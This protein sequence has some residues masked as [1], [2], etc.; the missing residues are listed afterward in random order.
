MRRFFERQ[1]LRSVI[2]LAAPIALL[3]TGLVLQTTMATLFAGRLGPQS[4]AT[5]GLAGSTYFLILIAA[6]GLLLGIDP[7]SSQAFGAGERRECAEVLVHA[8]ILAMLAA[9]P[10]FAVM[11]GTGWFLKAFGVEPALAA[12][13]GAY[14]RI[15]R[16]GVFP[17]LL[18]T[19]CR[20]YL[21]TLSITLP[22]LAGVVAADA[23]A[24]VLDYGLMFGHF[25][26]PALGVNGAAF[27]MLAA[28]CTMLAVVAVAAAR[29]VSSSGWLWT[30]FKTRIF[31]ELVRLGVPAS[32]QMLAEVGAFSLTSLLCGR[33]GSASS[34]AH[35]IVLN[36]ASLSFMV[37]LGVSHAAAVRVGQG[38]GHRRADRAVRSAWDALG[39]GIA[40]MSLTCLA[41]LLLGRAIMGLYTSDN[42]VMDLGVRLLAIAGV[43]QVFDAVQVIMT[44]S[45]RGLG[46]TRAPM[47]VNAVGYYLVG[48]PVGGYLAFGAGWGAFGLWIGVC[49]GLCSVAVGLLAFWVWR[50]RR[51][52]AEDPATAGVWDEIRAPD[53]I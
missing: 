16:W 24:A 21:Q 13:T 38:I 10:V 48:L 34:A 23:V 30:G 44:G 46:E 37:P 15:L 20:Q 29:Q 25:G 39:L 45:L 9:L 11:S 2:I 53:P 40:F 50:S 36:L 18:F 4:I 8:V 12:S 31:R 43:F 6:F 42:G 1:E 14:L 41:Y 17:M 19:A 47:I 52:L 32:G 33:M 26:L 49:L 51:L 27:A 35:Q 28:S 5:V 7:L 22:Q 3:Q